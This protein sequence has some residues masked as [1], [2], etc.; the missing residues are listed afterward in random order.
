MGPSKPADSNF[1]NNEQ[2]IR[3]TILDVTK[4]L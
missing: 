1:E 2:S 4:T 3:T